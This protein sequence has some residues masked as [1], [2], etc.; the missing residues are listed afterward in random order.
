[1]NDYLLP[2]CINVEGETTE[3][4][5][6]EIDDDNNS[7]ARIEDHTYNTLDPKLIDPPSSYDEVRGF[8]LDVII[9]HGILKVCVVHMCVCVY[10]G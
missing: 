8:Y 10:Y 7:V 2:F 6:Y 3:G 5:Y 1:M 9:M 4:Q